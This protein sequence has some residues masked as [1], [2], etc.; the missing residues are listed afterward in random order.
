MC[1]CLGA[2]VAKLQDSLQYAVHRGKLAAARVISMILSTLIEIRGL[3]MILL[4]QICS[5]ITPGERLSIRLENQIP[6]LSKK[7]SDI[8]KALFNDPQF[9]VFIVAWR[10]WWLM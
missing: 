10:V 6:F 9:I 4:H 3:E 2:G 7:S 5:R 1:V 8:P